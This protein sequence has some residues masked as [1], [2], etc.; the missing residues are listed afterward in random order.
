MDNHVINLLFIYKLALI[1][2]DN[3]LK[4]VIVEDLREIVNISVL[5]VNTI[6]SCLD[7]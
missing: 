2:K 6:L 5:V 3:S 4:P 7:T 1:V